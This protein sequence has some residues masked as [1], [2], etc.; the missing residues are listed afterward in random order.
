MR[1]TTDLLSWAPSVG[2]LAQ[3]FSIMVLTIMDM[4]VALDK[5][6]ISAEPLF[7]QY[8][9]GF[10]P[11]IFDRLL[12]AKEQDLRRSFYIEQYLCWRRDEAEPGCPLIFLEGN[13]ARSLAVVFFERSP[14][15][16]RLKLEIEAAAAEDRKK[17]LQGF[18]KQKVVVCYF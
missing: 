7:K 8:P 18:A 11:S 15:H 16:Q 10:P 5:C 13:T 1:E 9:P 4:W 6:T 12:L 14:N 2:N 17:K 3:S